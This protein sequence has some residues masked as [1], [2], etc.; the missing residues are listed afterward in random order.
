MRRLA[1]VARIA[2][3]VVLVTL[4]ALV[5]LV[6]VTWT[7]LQTRQGGELVRRLALPRVNAALAGRLTLGQLAF[8][9][10]RLTLE[11]VALYDPES[12]LVAHVARI[13][14]GFSPLALL[15]RHV[16]VRRLEIRRPE[17]TLVKDA[18]GLNLARALG[19]RAPSPAGTRPAGTPAG[20]GARVAIDVR[21]LAVTDGTID[22]RSSGEGQGGG[23]HLHVTDLS[24][25]GKASLSGDRVI[26]D[27]DVDARGVRV[28]ARGEYQLDGQDGRLT[29]H[30]AVRG[31]SLAADARIDGGV[32]SGR[33]RIDA[34][35]LATTSRAL[36][37]DFGLP[38]IAMT[39]DGRL[40]LALGGTVAAPSLR[41]TVA[42]PR[43]GFAETQARDLKVA[44]W[45]P[46]LGVP[47]ALDVD[48]GASALW[49]GKQR[50]HAPAV[51]VKAAGKDVALR[52]AVTGPQPLRLDLAGR[53]RGKAID[54]NAFALRY[55]QAT[56]TMRKPARL[57]FGDTI[58]LSGLELG[59]GAQRVTADVRIGGAT[60]TA[61]VV[62]S[63]LDLGRLPRALVPESV[64]LAGTFDA[65]LR[66]VLGDEPRVAAK[67]TLAGGRIGRH[68]DLSFDLDGVLD[69][70]RAHGRLQAR[71]LGTAA[72]ARF[73]LPGVWPPRNLRA[74]LDLQLDVADADLAA[75]AAAVAEAGGAPPA[76][77]R[78][79]ARLSAH[80]AGRVGQPR[81]QVTV[82]GRG[83]ALDDRNLGD[84]ELTVEGEGDGELAARVTT[85][86]PVRTRIDVSTPLSLRSILRRPPT[87]AALARTPFEV[88]GTVDRLP[89][90]LLAHA[91]GYPERVGGTLSANLSVT[92][93]AAAPEGTVAVD[94]AGAT[95][96]RFPPTDARVEVDFGDRGI[97]ARARV[98][99]RSVALLAAEGRFGAPLGALVEPS[100]L[101]AAPIRLRAV[102]GP[103][104]VQR[105]GLPPVSDREPPRE[106]HGR[107]HADV[108]VD[109]TVGAPRLLFHVQASDI[110]LDKALVGYAEI[111]ASYA[112]RRAKVDAHLK[113]H[114][115]GTLRANAAMTADL[116]YAAVARGFD[117]QRAPLDV[118][119]DAQDFDVQGLSGATRDLRKVGGLVT[120][121]L[122]LGGT[123]A[124]P[125]LGGRLDWKDG[126][127]AVTGFGEY[128]NIHLALHGDQANLVLDELSA[129]S[130]AGS[131][132]VVGH[133]THRKDHGYDIDAS[134]KLDRFPIYAEGQPLATVSLASRMNGR[135]SGAGARL[136]VDLDDAHIELSDAKRKDLQSLTVPADVVLM[137]GAKPLND[138]QAAKLRALLE[139]H[140]APGGE[141]KRPPR[142]RLTVN[143]PRQLWVKGRDANLELGLSPEFRVS[144]GERTRVYGQ[145]IVHRGRVDVFGRRF[146]V[147]ADSTL[148]FGGAPDHPDVDVRA[149]HTNT[150]ENI[151]V[152][153]AAKGPI[154]KL[155]VSVTSPNR[156]ELSESQL[157]T[158]IITGHLQLGG[159]TSG[160][161]PA[162][163]AAS[164]VGGLLV[165]KLQE[166]LSHRLPLDVLTIDTGEGIA[167]TKLE[168]GRY[169][170]D[171][172]YV[173]YVGRV[174]S[175]PTRYQN[176]NAVHL[177][178]QIT[179]RWEIE[180]E[181]GDLGTGTA[182]LMWKKNY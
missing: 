66:A 96:G 113:S 76:R 168:A 10:D 3:K 38:R 154:D 91:A 58:V 77:L 92:G 69:R 51:A 161:A 65:D 74:P 36:T 181:Y 97:D 177:E 50:L 20:R 162:A 33:A 137:D 49:I 95:T 88:K 159:G 116:G 41:A 9:G 31:V 160:A 138:A 48:A 178:Y 85:N 139:A 163:Q 171:R 56:W 2:A 101:A 146:D 106:L 142:L 105:L 107:V 16:D 148:T 126:V 67:A 32:V 180:G 18:D 39:G 21:A 57:A 7:F 150:T 130:G 156:P 122:T 136:T 102:F 26:A 8:G 134:T 5:L 179:S 71:G 68:R 118:R 182:D 143:A 75:V 152:L 170:T 35:D 151:T 115:G 73:D 120:G 72:E 98:V 19:P 46:D 127:V 124:D 153:I 125:R 70:G 53:R 12:R 157:Y 166:T 133:A 82:A 17:L 114:N 80:L 173:G 6:G 62:V 52:V 42:F 94:V 59:A 1:K 176:R 110:Y 145:V 140:Q 141:T 108:A 149:E 28:D 78:G 155:D 128:K 24:I 100:R 23:Q 30:A 175:D 135:A 27:A 93:T 15:R 132:R 37:R 158:L 81:L 167:G 64:G 119:L 109:G 99:R 123:A 11:N 90:A 44:A 87:A 45:I 89:L 25:R 34:A 63:R 83:L 144:V 29:A 22:Y 84:V 111:E 117:F 169:V 40:D 103:Y 43:L 54:L 60:P 147:K 165:S 14:V 4:A 131:A 61:H 129:S 86:A 47:E 174:G 55:P 79:H 13:D 112:D 164:I 172:L 104:L 121:S